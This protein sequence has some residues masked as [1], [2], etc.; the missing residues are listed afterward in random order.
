MEFVA[1]VHAVVA[2][3]AYLTIGAHFALTW[4]HGDGFDREQTRRNLGRMDMPKILINTVLAM[5]ISALVGSA[6]YGFL[7]LVAALI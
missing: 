7:T 4:N 5:V 3:V 2:V 1:A 6:W